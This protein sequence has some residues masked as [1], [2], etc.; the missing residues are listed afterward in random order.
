MYF[1]F[2]VKSKWFIIKKIYTF[3][4]KVL[5]KNK[6]L[7]NTFMNINFNSKS[8]VKG[9]L[10]ISCFLFSLVVFSQNQSE[11][12][13]TPASL[14]LTRFNTANYVQGGHVAIFFEP[15]GVFELDNEFV[16]ELSDVNGSFTT[17]TEIS[18]K[19]EFYLPAL[20]GA[21]PT[22]I[23]PGSNYKIEGKIN[24]SHY[25]LRNRSI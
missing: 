19:S 11:D 5:C 10:L 20:N 7:K 2:K 21:I 14:N 22:D 6:M 13:S 17:S 24:S 16:L 3:E 8:F 4:V 15:E 18:R 1:F 9:F 23:A 25:K 12:C